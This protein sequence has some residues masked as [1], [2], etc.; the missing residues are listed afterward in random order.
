[1]AD[2]TSGENNTEQVTIQEVSDDRS[3]DS[4]ADI[5][6][7]ILL[8]PATMIMLAFLSVVYKIFINRRLRG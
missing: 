6:G 2:E 7:A 4:S 1:M 3:V 5:V 8:I